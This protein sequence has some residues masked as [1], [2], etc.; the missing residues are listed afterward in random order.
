MKPGKYFKKWYRNPN[1]K[2]EPIRHWHGI[3]HYPYLELELR[4]AFEKGRRYQ[5]IY[6]KRCNK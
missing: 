6:G 2:A 3:P 1:T 4:K 5:K